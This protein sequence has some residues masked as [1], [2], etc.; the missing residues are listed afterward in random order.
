[1]GEKIKMT[2][3]IFWNVDTQYDFMKPEGR[4]A[5]SGATNIERNLEYLTRIAAER[6][7]KVVNTADYHNVDSRELSTTP[8]YTTTF[9][10]HCLAG[11][12]GVEFI[13]ATKPVNPYVIDWKDQ[14]FDPS[15]LEQHRNIVIYKDEF[16]AFHP[17]GAPHTEKVLSQLNPQRAIVYGVATNVCVDF[18]V[19]GLLQRGV[20]VYVPLDAIKELP[21][22]PLEE[23]LKSWR[24]KG[25]ILIR[26]NEISKYF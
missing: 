10:P 8:N 2:K 5:I 24:M 14:S 16:D 6:K 9:P 25:A 12:K 15:K 7:I 23:V 18:A 19:K 20:E 4:L 3:I 22:L 26:T 17:T 11:T 21:G 1:M 13:D